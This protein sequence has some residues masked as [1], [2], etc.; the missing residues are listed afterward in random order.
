MEMKVQ[1]WRRFKLF[2]PCRS[3]RS[4][5]R[6]SGAGGLC[7]QFHYIYRFVYIFPSSCSLEGVFFLPPRA[8]LILCVCL[9][10]CP[11]SEW[12]S[13]IDSVDEGLDAGARQSSGRRV[14]SLSPETPLVDG[15]SGKWVGLKSCGRC[16][17]HQIRTKINVADASEVMLS[18]LFE[19]CYKTAAQVV[20]PL[21]GHKGKRLFEGTTAPSKG[22]FVP[23]SETMLRL[24]WFSS[25]G[26]QQQQQKWELH[27][28]CFLNMLVLIIFLK[29]NGCLMPLFLSSSHRKCTTKWCSRNPKAT[30]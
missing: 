3:K 23:P 19:V 30:R 16:E 24:P 12:D 27:L 28:E 29:C 13:F 22:M 11:Q 1:F 21:W 10:V 26:W 25:L 7:A 8:W 4:S 17:I 6:T 15:G 5:G 20:G 9:S 14:D 2:Q 18:P